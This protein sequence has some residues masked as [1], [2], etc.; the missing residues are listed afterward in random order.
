MQGYIG[1]SHMYRMA[2]YLPAD[3]ISLA[4]PGFK[5]STESIVVIKEKL[6]A[7]SLS[8]SDTV[9]LDLL[10]N[11]AYMGTDVDGL[12]LPAERAGDSRYH[13]PGSL[14]TAP[15]TILKKVLEVC[16]TLAEPI[17][18]SNVVLVCPI[19]LYV[20][21]SCCTDPAHIENR[22]S[23]TLKTNWL[24]V[25]NN[26]RGWWAVAVGLRFCLMD[27]TAVVHPTEPLLRNRL[28]SNGLS[29]WCPG[30]PVHL[31]QEAYR[32]LAHAL[33]E[34][35]DDDQEDAGSVSSR[36]TEDRSALS[37]RSV[38]CSTGSGRENSRTRW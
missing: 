29:I 33:I 31:S 8:A 11:S 20:M 7:L 28:T 17:K 36:L 32:D 25:K 24:T 21:G 23:K 6:D 30:D 5:P 37:P 16:S 1:A 13:I 4:Y 15:P 27:P 34:V 14:T 9:V 19:P 22:K 10:S 35:H 3:S 18:Q 2:E 38:T 12:P 26:T